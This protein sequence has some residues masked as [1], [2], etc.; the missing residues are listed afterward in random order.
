MPATAKASDTESWEFNFLNRFLQA[1]TQ[2]STSPTCQEQ[3]SNKNIPKHLPPHRD[4]PPAAQSPSTVAARLDRD[5]VVVGDEERAAPADQVRHDDDDG[6]A[7]KPA[8]QPVLARA[9]SA[10]HGSDLATLAAAAAAA[11]VR[12]GTTPAPPTTEQA[13]R[14]QLH[15][16]VL[17][18]LRDPGVDDEPE[19]AEHADDL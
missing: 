11:K 16:P 12:A 18:R 6:H 14:L 9:D 7:D 17:Q 10:I 2:A 3:H 5:G 15:L 19:H 4:A 1:S 8:T 13:G